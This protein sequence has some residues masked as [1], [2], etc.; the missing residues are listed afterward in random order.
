MRLTSSSATAVVAADLTKDGVNE[1]LVGRNDGRIEVFAQQ[2]GPG[3][4]MALQPV[5]VYSATIGETVRSVKCGLVNSS[6]FHEVG[7]IFI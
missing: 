1:V 2:G 7:E 5:R 6:D 3:G 4:G